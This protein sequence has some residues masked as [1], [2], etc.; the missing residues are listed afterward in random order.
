MALPTADFFDVLLTFL[1]SIKVSFSIRSSK[2]CSLQVTGIAFNLSGVVPFTQSLKKQGRRLNATRE[3]R[4]TPTYAPDR[5]LLVKVREP[6]PSLKVR[7][8]SSPSDLLVGEE[9]GGNLILQNVGSVSLRDL[10]VIVDDS[11]SLQVLGL[12]DQ[13]AKQDSEG[14]HL[15]L[16][17]DLDLDLPRDIELPSGILEAGASIEVPIAIRGVSAGLNETRCLFV[18]EVSVWK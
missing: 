18:F 3:Q 12:E 14:D 8:E 4:L 5:S 2:L 15:V 17:N 13:D 9:W 11:T 16:R 1:S 7:L 6:K 10:R